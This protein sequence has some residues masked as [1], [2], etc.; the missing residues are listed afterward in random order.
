MWGS[1]SK[2]QRP[3]RKKSLRERLGERLLRT[4][5]KLAEKER[6]AGKKTKRKTKA[7]RKA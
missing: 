5:E 4:N 6:R 7:A 2:L 1:K 3:V